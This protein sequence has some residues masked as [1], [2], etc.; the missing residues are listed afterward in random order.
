M[1]NAWPHVALT[2]LVA[3]CRDAVKIESGVDYRLL[4]VRWYGEGAFH[5][6]TVTRETSKATTIYKVVP[7]QF[8]YN[9]LFAGKGAFGLVLPEFAGAFVSNEF[10]LF[11]TDTERLSAEYLNSLIPVQ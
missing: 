7:G 6:E 2:E 5:R 3:Q 9:R 1:S 11:D 10:P 4:G 8:I